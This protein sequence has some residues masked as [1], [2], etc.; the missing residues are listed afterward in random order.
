MKTYFIGLILGVLLYLITILLKLDN[1]FVSFMCGVI[2][3][4]IALVLE[5]KGWLK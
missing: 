3:M 5:S 1:F 4:I 2:G